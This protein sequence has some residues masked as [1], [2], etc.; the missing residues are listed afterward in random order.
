MW[1]NTFAKGCVTLSR[2][3]HFTNRNIPVSVSDKQ[4]SRPA[5]ASAL[6]QLSELSDF[7]PSVRSH[8]LHQATELT[9]LT[10]LTPLA[11]HWTDP[12]GTKYEA[13]LKTQA[14]CYVY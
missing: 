4:A 10:P 14:R 7:S 9:S 5:K 1:R 6:S 3:S 12:S 13:K 2:L 8:L 11:D